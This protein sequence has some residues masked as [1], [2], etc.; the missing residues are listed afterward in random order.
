MIS[1][2]N[3]YGKQRYDKFSICKWPEEWKTHDNNND[4]PVQWGWYEKAKLRKE[5]LDDPKL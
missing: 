2:V 1:I 4:R 5:I 3:G